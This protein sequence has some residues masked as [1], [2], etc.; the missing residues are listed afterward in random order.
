MHQSLFTTDAKIINLLKQQVRRTEERQMK[1]ESL[2]WVSEQEY[3]AYAVYN[4]QKITRYV[5][6]EDTYKF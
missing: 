3:L 2:S 6:R 5:V 4:I 1:T